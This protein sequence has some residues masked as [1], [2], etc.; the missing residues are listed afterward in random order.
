MNILRYGEYITEKAAFQMLLESKAVFSQKMVNLLNRMNSNKIAKEILSFQS[1]DVD[2]IAQ[3]YIDVTDSKEDFSF[4]PD[5][6][7]Q[8]MVAGRPE[9]YK[10]TNSGRYLT[11]SDRNN[12]IFERLGYDKTVRP[13]WAPET[14]TLLKI[15]AETQSVSGKTYCMVEEVLEEGSGSDIRIGVINKEAMELDSDDLKAIWKTARNPV[16]VGRFARAF[17]TA[18]KVEFNDRDIEE[19]VNQYKATFDFAQNALAQF[20][21][22]KGNDI[23][24]WYWVDQY[25]RGGG[26]LNNSCMAEADSEWLYIYSKNKQVSLV[27]LYDDNGTVTDGKYTSKKIKGRAILWE[28]KVDG[29]DSM[30]LDRIYTVHDSDV[31]LFKQFA[32][33]NGWWY[34]KSQSM[35]PDERITNGTQELR[36]AK[37]ACKVDDANPSG[38]YPYMD[39]MCFININD[40][41]IGNSLDTVDPDEKN[42]EDYDDYHGQIRV[43]RTTDGD[44]FSPDNY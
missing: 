44:W 43:A 26:T 23:I 30:F 14:G 16:K 15:L 37:I 25:Q 2:G 42:S 13:N 8:Q 5:R 33:K 6:K 27:V 21:I 31:E 11:H 22:V 7:V 10:V 3:N 38:Y 40:N 29:Q 19:F 24:H 17:L 32:E 9:I 1:K 12:K 36:S 4:T 35:D 34:K 39:T 41:I 20:D 28:C 18:A